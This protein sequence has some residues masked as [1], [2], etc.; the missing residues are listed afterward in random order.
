MKKGLPG[1]VRTTVLSL[2]CML[3]VAVVGVMAFERTS[4]TG[5]CLSC[6]EMERHE[7]ELKMSPHAVDKDKHPIECR[8]CHLPATFGPR[9]VALKAYLGVKDVVVHTFGD[10]VNDFYRRELQISARRFVPDDSCRA[11]HQ[12]LGKDVK[13]K[14]LPREGKLAHEAYLAT[15][16]R[17]DKGCAN[18]HQNMAHLPIFD[19]R[20]VENAEFAAKLA[21]H[22]EGN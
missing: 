12:D 21:G 2:A 8:Q 19:R 11:C 9:Y 18:C 16:G 17:T 1:G 7:A 15:N 20:Y 4:T 14:P 22:E 3:A 13:G 5:F 10:P 6:H